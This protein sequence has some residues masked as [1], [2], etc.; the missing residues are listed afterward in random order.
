MSVWWR[1]VLLGVAIGLALALAL[2]AWDCGS[3]R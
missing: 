2:G 3:P 1:A